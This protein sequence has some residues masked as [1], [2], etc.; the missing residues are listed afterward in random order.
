MNTSVATSSPTTTP[1]QSWDSSEKFRTPSTDA[2][3]TAFEPSIMDYT[4]TISSLS[5]DG[6]ISSSWEDSWSSSPTVTTSI[7][8]G[9]GNNLPATRDKK[10][11][12]LPVPAGYTTSVSTS[13][14]SPRTTTSM[15]TNIIRGVYHLAT[16]TR[17]VTVPTIAEVVPTESL[18]PTTERARLP[19]VDKLGIILAFVL[20]I[21][22]AVCFFR[23]KR[24][25]A[26]RYVSNNNL[27]GKYPHHFFISNV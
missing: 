21:F 1:L 12:S 25:F 17:D 15:S 19:T 24:R 10:T 9:S 11:T 3:A 23:I 18:P 6:T 20:F 27:P 2:T 8:Q 26:H 14:F 13:T 5:F 22:A 16:T 4:R 7:T